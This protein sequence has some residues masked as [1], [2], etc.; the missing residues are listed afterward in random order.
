MKTADFD[1]LLPEALI[2][3]KPLKERT[4]SRLLVLHRDGTLEHKNFFDL[5]SYL[6]QGDILLINN[7]KVFPARLTGAKK[8]GKI[9]I[10]QVERL[11]VTIQHL[12]KKKLRKKSVLV[13]SLIGVILLLG[14]A[15]YYEMVQ[16][17]G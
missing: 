4:S 16:I 14:I 10:I 2:A 9:Y 15:A 3:Q 8:D 1:Y 5:P 13:F 11:K 6:D 17:F 7:T 12:K